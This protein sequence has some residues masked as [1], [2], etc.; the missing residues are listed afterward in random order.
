SSMLAAI[1]NERALL[2][3]ML[4]LVLLVAGFGVFAILSMMVSE[5]RRDIGILTALGATPR[6]ILSLFLSIGGIEALVGMVLGVLVGITAAHNIN[7]IE[8]WLSGV[9]GYQ[10]FD[11]EVY[12]FDHIPTVIEWTG[13]VSIAAA[14]VFTAL[15]AAAVPALRAAYLNPVDALRYE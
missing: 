14:S 5:K 13:I 7:E 11:R 1:E 3:I 6:G 9:T 15:L 8:T 12:Y 2:G 4:G 10:L